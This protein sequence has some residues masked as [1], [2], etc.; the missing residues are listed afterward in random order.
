LPPDQV[1]RNLTQKLLVYGT[2]HAIEFS[3]RAA[4][5]TIVAEVRA[6]NYG[7]RTMVHAIVQGP[8]FRS[9]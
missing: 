6:K 4:V 9:K 5:E 7:F 2:G 3:D 8:T 1:A